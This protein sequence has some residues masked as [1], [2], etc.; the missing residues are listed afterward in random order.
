MMNFENKANIYTNTV[1][2]KKCPMCNNRLIYF[3]TIKK[4]Y[5]STHGVIE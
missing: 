3:Y 2:F 4:L 5:C 1:I